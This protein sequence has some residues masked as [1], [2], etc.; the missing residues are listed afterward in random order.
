[1][2]PEPMPPKPRKPKNADLMDVYQRLYR[3]YG[4]RN[5]WPGEGPFE[6]IAGAILTQNTAWR[7]V[8]LAL[9]NMREARLWSF[10]ALH[11]VEKDRLASVIRPSGYYN[12]KA[13]K[14]KEFAAVVVNDFGGSLSAMLALDATVLRDRLLA[15]WGIGEETADDIVLYV[16]NKPSFVIDAYT[17][18]IV[19]RLGWQT[20]GSAYADYQNMFTRLLPKDAQLFNEYHALLDAHASRVCKKKPLCSECTLG[21]ICM[22]GYAAQ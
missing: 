1:M 17:R 15:V 13:R 11:E 5:W 19:D 4:P 20:G 2:E 21:D 14:L 22:T 3:E 16:A 7:N 6:I 8:R 12:Q 18:R 9:H 10:Q